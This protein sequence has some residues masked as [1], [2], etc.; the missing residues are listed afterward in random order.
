MPVIGF[1]GK[2]LGLWISEL[3]RELASLRDVRDA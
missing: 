1:Y 2:V 3:A